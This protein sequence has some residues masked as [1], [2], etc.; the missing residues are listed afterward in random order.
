MGYDLT[1]SDPVGYETE[2]EVNVI[3]VAYNVHALSEPKCV[4]FSEA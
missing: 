4:G 3:A 1:G 2:E